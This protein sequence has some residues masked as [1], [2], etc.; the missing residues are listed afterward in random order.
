VNHRF[1]QLPDQF[2][3]CIIKA[4]A[5]LIDAKDSNTYIGLRS[6]INNTLFEE[7]NEA[8]LSVRL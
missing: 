3:F 5:H 6:S 8:V 1:R 7:Y 4:C 2:D